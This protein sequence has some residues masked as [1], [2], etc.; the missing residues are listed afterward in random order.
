VATSLIARF[1]SLSAVAPA[2]YHWRTRA[3]AEVDL[4]LERDG[5]FWPIEIKSAARVTTGD[6]RGIR[7]FRETYPHLRHAPGIVMAAVEQ[8]QR[9]P[10]NCLVLP[11]DL[12]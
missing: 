10:D 12:R 11:Y 4:L 2:L 8:P 5:C 1:R 6:T 9:L 7:A 3:G